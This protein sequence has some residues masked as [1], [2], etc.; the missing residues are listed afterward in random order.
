MNILTVLLKESI[1]TFI[2][3]VIQFFRNRY[4]YKDVR[5]TGKSRNYFRRSKSPSYRS[6]RNKSISRS[7]SRSRTPSTYGKTR[8]HS[9][10]KRRYRSRSRSKSYSRRSRSKSRKRSRSRQRHRS[11]SRSG[12]YRRSKHPSNDKFSSDS[13]EEQKPTK[14]SKCAADD[15]SDFNQLKH[16]NSDT[17]KI[18]IP[19]GK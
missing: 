6:K 19:S 5:E 7:R 2:R 11:R 9:K 12:S 14:D 18:V 16:E 17:T 15:Y 3:T 1:H 10:S 8:V 13:A 4:S